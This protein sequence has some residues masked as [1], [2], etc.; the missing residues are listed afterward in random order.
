MFEISEIGENI[1]RARKAAGITQ[2]RLGE[3]I[4]VGKSAVQKYESGGVKEIKHS[5]IIR[6]CRALNVPPSTLVGDGNGIA[7][8]IAAIGVEYGPG[9]VQLLGR[10]ARLNEAGR[11]RMLVMANDLVRL[12][13][14]TKE[15]E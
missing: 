3:M 9:A 1:K 4:G 6:I 15:E 14:Y 11:K 2:E 7:K 12:D 13:D 5:T 10:Y 8:A